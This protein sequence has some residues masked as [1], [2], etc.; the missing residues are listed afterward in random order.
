MADVACGPFGSQSFC[1]RY[2]L[3]C[4]CPEAIARISTVCAE[5]YTMYKASFGRKFTMLMNER[6]WKPDRAAE[7]FGVSP[8]MIVKYQNGENFPEGEALGRMADILDVSIDWMMGRSKS[9]KVQDPND[10]PA[11]NGQ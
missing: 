4:P 1:A 7:V 10:S 3:P 2:G 9:R 6:G 11:L 5:V 8:T